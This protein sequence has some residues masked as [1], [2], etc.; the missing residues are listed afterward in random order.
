MSRKAGRDSIKSRTTPANPG[1]RSPF[2]LAIGIAAVAVLLLFAG[3]YYFLPRSP[4]SVAS[5]SRISFVRASLDSGKRDLLVVNAD[6]TGQEQ[7]TN[8][9]LV[10]GTALWSPDGKHIIL[11]AGVANISTIVR[12]TIGSDNKPTE[13]VQLTAD[14][15][16][17]CAFPAWSPDGKMVAFQ[18]KKDGANW[19]VFVMDTDGNNKRRLSNSSDFA[20]QP[21]WSPDGLSVAYVQGDATAGGIRE[22][23]VVP[24]SGGAPRKITSLGSNLTNPVWSPKG[25]LITALQTMGQYDVRLLIMRP[26]GTDQRTLAQD[27]SIKGQE[28]SPDGTFIAYDKV[29]PDSGENVFKVN[30]ADGTTTNISQGSGPAYLSTWSPDGTQL[31]WSAIQS[32][33]KTHKIVVANADGSNFHVVST[34]D[35][36]DYQPSWSV[37]K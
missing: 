30:V 5:A 17:D 16:A 14:I 19:Q 35:G 21:A 24:V 22:L 15:K 8:D 1:A 28:F 6:G 12:L 10:E 33:L 25:D 36:D 29:A 2:P 11:Q 7:V 32:S 13:A 34:G 18:S 3:L 26:D 27:G 37:T 20:G 4:Q 9:L 23:Y 31:A